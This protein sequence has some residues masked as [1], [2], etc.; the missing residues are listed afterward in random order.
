MRAFLNIL[1]RFGKAVAYVAD[2]SR[3]Y[4]CS[5]GLTQPTLRS[6]E[7]TNPAMYS[8]QRFEIL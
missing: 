3:Q 2:S 7:P 6:P 4:P 1:V 5:L 8:D